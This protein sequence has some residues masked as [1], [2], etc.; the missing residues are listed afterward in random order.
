MYICKLS[1]PVNPFDL[2]KN[3]YSFRTA[4]ILFALNRNIV[5]LCVGN[6]KTNYEYRHAATRFR[7]QNVFSLCKES[8]L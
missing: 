1:F 7:S 2:G 5:L 4:V 6:A 3:L 8:Q